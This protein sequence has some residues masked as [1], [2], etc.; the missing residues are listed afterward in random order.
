[1]LCALTSRINGLQ[2]E[3][4][5]ET[6]VSGEPAS[7]SGPQQNLFTTLAGFFVEGAAHATNKHRST[8][9]AR[10]SEPAPSS[11]TES[12]SARTSCSVLKVDVSVFG[13]TT[14]SFFASLAL[15]T[16]RI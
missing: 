16:A 10:R 6:T 2:A 9:I 1:M 4:L 5:L 11:R 14:P 8:N 13:D 12:H 7:S 3:R 15:S